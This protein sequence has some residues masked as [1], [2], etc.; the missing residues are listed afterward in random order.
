MEEANESYDRAIALK[1]DYAVAYNNRGTVFQETRHFQEAEENYNRAT[2]IRP[3]YAEAHL[4]QSLLKLLTGDYLGGW[5]L[6]E[7][8]WKTAGK[9]SAG[10]IPSKAWGISSN[11]AVISQRSKKKGLKSSSWC[12]ARSAGYFPAHGNVT[13]WSKMGKSCP[14]STFTAP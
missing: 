7:W 13:R 6:H 14:A 5:P 4:N 11:S 2:A 10:P 9:K 12:R 8:R 3:D 1:T